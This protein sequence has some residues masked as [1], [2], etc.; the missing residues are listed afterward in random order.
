MGSLVRVAGLGRWALVAG[1]M[2]GAAATDGACAATG[3]ADAG[4]ADAKSAGPPGSSVRP[5][6]STPAA[7]VAGGP[8][9]DPSG[10]AALPD[11]RLT[12]SRG[13]RFRTRT[14]RGGP[15]AL[16]FFYTRCALPETC[17]RLARQLSE[18]Q[19]LIGPPT[20]L[21]GRARI[22]TVTLDPEYDTPPR[23]AKFGRERG[24]DPALWILATG[25]SASLARLRA[26]AGVKTRGR[27]TRMAH[28]EGVL[29]YRPDGTFFRRMEGTR[30]T[31]R[32]LAQA[33]E[34]AG[35]D[36]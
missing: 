28:D 16:A 22:L 24:A 34:E 33:M 31:P 30:W 6:R 15:V 2:S 17:P 10:L 9:E 8:R 21:Q 13:R 4:A 18:T 35:R 11:I 36:R 1:L 23:L 20:E 32:E 25:D 7:R 3:L 27:G 12:D 5:A 19:E 29:V 26:A 14:L